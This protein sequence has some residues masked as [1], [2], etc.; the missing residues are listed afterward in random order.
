MD[1]DYSDFNLVMERML[2][3]VSN[4]VDK[5]EGSVIWDAIAPC[6]RELVNMYAEIIA[7]LDN[8]FAGTATRPWLIKKCLEIGI[9][10]YPATYAIRKA[11]FSPA[12]INIPIGER[13]SYE[14][15]DFKVTEKLPSGSTD[16]KVI[17]HVQ[18]EQAGEVG[19]DGSGPLIPINY[20]R[21][22]ETATL[23]PEVVIYGEEEE[24]TEALRQRFFD[25]LPAMTLDGNV[26]QYQKWCREYA[27][28]G[29]FKV[30]P[31]WAGKNTVKVSILSSENTIAS[32]YLIDQFQEFL[33][34]KASPEDTHGEGVGMGKAPI[35]AIVTVSTP[36]EVEIDVHAKLSLVAGFER[37][38]GIEDELTAYLHSL[39]YNKTLVSYVSISAVLDNNYT[40]N[41]AIEVT[42]NGG[43]ENI[44]LGDE[45][46][47]KLGSFT[48][49]VVD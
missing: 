25:T 44:P 13:F 40:V 39:N 42:V 47:C 14:D 41:T 15:V 48:Y 18:C 33:D 9:K 20:I 16:N 32:K 43:K 6:A 3:N 8:T 17:Y 35:G 45:E 19:N 21:G 22:L 23:L 30:F 34:P 11:E 4:E 7:A 12:T 5:R 49:E 36:I 37:P 31:E 28:I 27:G 24:D 29:N 10:P 1:F 38:V 46:I 26:A 2:G